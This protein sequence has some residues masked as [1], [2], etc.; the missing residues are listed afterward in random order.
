V[1]YPDINMLY[2]L[3]HTHY[4]V[5]V[6]VIVEDLTVTVKCRIAIAAQFLNLNLRLSIM[7]NRLSCS[8]ASIA[9]L[10]NWLSQLSVVHCGIGKTLLFSLNKKHNLASTWVHPRFV[11]GVRVAHL[12]I[13]LCCPIMRLYYV[14]PVLWCPLRFPHTNDAWF[15]FTSNFL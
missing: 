13:C 11:G 9:L 14:S 4:R 1:L 5:W 15:V 6:M 10:T 3:F 8:F 2:T 7:F 12:L